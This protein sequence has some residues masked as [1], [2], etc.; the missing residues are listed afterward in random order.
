MSAWL[1]DWYHRR[2]VLETS[3]CT[4]LLP[5]TTP[6]R[7]YNRIYLSELVFVIGPI[8]ARTR[9]GAKKDG[10][11]SHATPCSWPDLGRILA[12][13]DSFLAPLS[14]TLELIRFLVSLPRGERI[15]KSPANSAAEQSGNQPA[16]RSSL[17]SLCLLPLLLPRPSHLSSVAVASTCT[18]TCVY[19]ETKGASLR[20]MLPQSGLGEIIIISVYVTSLE[21]VNLK[22]KLPSVGSASL[23]PPPLPHPSHLPGIVRAVVRSPLLLYPTADS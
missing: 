6:D 18:H 2:P 4:F 1:I 23:V 20:L 17:A 21:L 9:P 3:P 15:G 12:N 22:R 5:F 8:T 10:T 13:G 16:Y 14:Q 19:Q 11:F 7:D